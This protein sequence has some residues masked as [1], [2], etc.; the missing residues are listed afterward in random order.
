MTAG[1]K[2][3]VSSSLMFV[4]DELL[5]KMYCVR[6]ADR[7]LVWS[8]NLRTFRQESVDTVYKNDTG[9]GLLCQSRNKFTIIQ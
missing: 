1:L 3:T 4:D 5:I 2:Q 7:V 9:L 8:W 6:T